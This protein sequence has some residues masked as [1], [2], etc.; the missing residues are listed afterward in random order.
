MIR[1]LLS[2]THLLLRYGVFSHLPEARLDSLEILVHG[3][4]DPMDAESLIKLWYQGDYI[5]LPHGTE[6]FFRTNMLLMRMGRKPI[7]ACGHG[8]VLECGQ[9]A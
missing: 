3:S 6:L 9:E 4:G 2:H 8:Q 5:S 1:D 7:D